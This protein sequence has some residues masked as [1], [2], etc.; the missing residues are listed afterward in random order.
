MKYIYYGHACFGLE[1][2]GSH[3]LFDPFITPNPLAQSVDVNAI[4]ADYILITHGHADHIA[5]AAAIARR[6]GALVISNFE[7]ITWLNSQGITHTHPMNLGG[8][9]ALPFGTLRS[10]VAHHSSVLPDGTYGGN[11]GGFVIQSPEGSIYAS[12]DTALTLDMKLIGERWPVQTAIVC[13]GDNF[14][15]GPADAAQATQWV[16]ARR[17]IGIH[18]N[19]F[20]YIEIDT[21]AAQKTFA[22]HGLELLLPAIGQTL[23]I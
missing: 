22:D 1:I 18:Y 21:Q 11:P 12:G 7:I 6:T 17:A 14:T 3:L 16:G 5:D 9:K 15:M 8:T 19:T 13:I 10:V 23:T 20:P 4:P 2:G